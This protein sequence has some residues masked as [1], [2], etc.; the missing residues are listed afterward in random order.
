MD[1]Y[2]WLK[3]NGIETQSVLLLPDLPKDEVGKD[4]PYM[5]H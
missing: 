2:R 1:D 3:G 5:H 4:D